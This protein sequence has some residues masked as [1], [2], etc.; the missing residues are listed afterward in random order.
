MKPR[1]DRIA[2]WMRR[3]TLI[4]ALLWGAAL[5]TGQ[6]SHP[7]VI[8][9]GALAAYWCYRLV[10]TS[11]K[12]SWGRTLGGMTLVVLVWSL[13]VLEM[14]RFGGG[15]TVLYALL[16]LSHTI[17]GPFL[18]LTAPIRTFG[19]RRSPRSLTSAAAETGKPSTHLTSPRTTV[20]SQP[21][22]PAQ[23]AATRPAPSTAPSPTVPAPASRPTIEEPTRPGQ[24]TGFEPEAMR[25]GGISRAAF[26]YGAPEGDTVDL[27]KALSRTGLLDRLATF[28]G[29][30]I[31]TAVGSLVMTGKSIYVVQLRREPQGDVTWSM[32]DGK[33]IAVDNPTGALVG[34]P[35]T[36]PGLEIERVK[37]ALVQEL[38]RCGAPLQVTPAIVLL[39]TDLGMGNVPTADWSGATGYAL[40]DFM[41]RI[42]R[43]P[44]FDYTAP[45]A[46]SLVSAL[47][48]LTER[49]AS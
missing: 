38:K 23:R 10:A 42:S 17:W 1:A 9:A 12:P 30:D 31:G 44:H 48:E 27:A 29:V 35:W 46:R 34:E 16:A 24:I 45:W 14:G 15:S 5:F 11:P 40:P 37:S 3:L 2:R 36:I 25:A 19:A 43:E 7:G 26:L 47:R 20:A 39:P 8:L 41:M 4:T 6:A 18:F 49:G 32:E 13:G 22:P 21:Q 28:W 33:L